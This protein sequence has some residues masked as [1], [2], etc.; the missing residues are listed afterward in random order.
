MSA[1]RRKSLAGLNLLC[2][3]CR[4]SIYLHYDGDA[5]ASGTFPNAGLVTAGLDATSDAL[6]LGG[7]YTFETPVLESRFSQ[8]EGR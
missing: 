1:D 3:F 8:F 6:I 4:E 5:S 2:Q 7:L